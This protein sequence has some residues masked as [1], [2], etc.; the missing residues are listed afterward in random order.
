MDKLT[1]GMYQADLHWEDPGAN[2]EAV[3]RQLERLDPASLPDL[4]LLPEMFSTGF[5]MNAEA[6]SETEEGDTVSWMISTAQKFDI[7]IM[8]SL[9]LED[10]GRYFNRLLLVTPEGI[11]GRYDKRH[12]FTLAGEHEVF[13]PG[14]NRAIFEYKGWK[15]CPQVC[16][17]LRFPV[18]SRNDLGYDLLVYLANW[19]DRR[20]NAWD[21]LLQARAI[22]NMCFVAGVNRVGKDGNSHLYTG[23]TAVIDPM[24]VRLLY[25]ESEELLVCELDR[26]LLQE[27][28][29]KLLFLEDRDQFFV[30]F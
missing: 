8:G 16:Y 4:L 25:T 26:S 1:I 12:L 30:R 21:V 3:L 28:R 23:H 24:G 11:A 9:I 20:I 13:T 10:E 2:R 7:G 27:S 6:L 19:P 22:E 29:Q 17:D 5:S 15:I 18:W 14:R